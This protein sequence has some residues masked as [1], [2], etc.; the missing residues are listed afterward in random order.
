MTTKSIDYLLLN[1]ENELNI[2]GYSNERHNKNILSKYDIGSFSDIDSLLECKKSCE[3]NDSSKSRL[4][5]DVKLK[6][7]SS[8]SSS[9]RSSSSKSGK[10]KSGKPKSGKPKNV[11]TTDE[12]T[13][14]V[15]SKSV[16]SKSDSSSGKPKSGKPKSGKLKSG[17][18]KSGK[19]KSGKPKSGKPKSGKLKTDSIVKE[20]FHVVNHK[21]D[22]E[23]LEATIRLINN[24]INS[25]VDDIESI[26]QPL[27]KNYKFFL[28]RLKSL[29]KNKKLF[30]KFVVKVTADDSLIDLLRIENF[31]YESYNN[32]DN[33]IE[34]K[35][36]ESFAEDDYNKTSKSIEHF[37]N[38]SNNM[39]IYLI[40]GIFLYMMYNNCNK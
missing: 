34:N 5:E 4:S 8:K 35:L 3:K 37:G 31:D 15:S 22:K 26:P 20:T 21:L 18:L 29:L 12:K 9:S 36:L 23:T 16:S 40:V 27:H 38:S 7:S 11:L 17:K 33:V 32:I 28:D 13:K 1:Q 24:K 2:D 6:S 39:F 25:M 14:S 19:P 10:P 30:I